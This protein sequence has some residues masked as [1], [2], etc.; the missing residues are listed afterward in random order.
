MRCIKYAKTREDEG[1]WRE[2]IS[3]L[4]I[5]PKV[6]PISEIPGGYRDSQSCDVDYA[7]VDSTSGST[8][9]PILHEKKSTHARGNIIRGRTGYYV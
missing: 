2:V 8:R 3:H 5:I 9:V 1:K 6:M 7:H 4:G